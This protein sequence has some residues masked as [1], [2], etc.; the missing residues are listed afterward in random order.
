MNTTVVNI[1]AELNVPAWLSDGLDRGTVFDGCITGIIDFSAFVVVDGVSG[2]LK[3]SDFSDDF[4]H[5]SEHYKCHDHIKVRCKKACFVNG[6][7]HV[8]WEAPVKAH[9][10]QPVRC[11]LSVGMTVQAK[12]TSVRDLPAGRAA[13]ARTSEGGDPVDILCAA[14][15]AEGREVRPGEVRQILISSVN[16]NVAWNEPPRLRGRVLWER[17]SGERENPEVHQYQVWWAKI[18][19]EG[20][21]QN[22]IRPVVIV[23]NNAANVYSSV[24][25]AVPLTK[26]EKPELPTHVRTEAN[27]TP[28]IALC[29]NLISLDKSRLISC[30]DVITDAE[31]L[32]A[33][34]RALMLQLGITA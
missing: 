1:A 19:A 20:R 10:T 9:R 7:L 16:R 15:D 4:S 5:I 14:M 29:E 8:W 25:T 27:H 28:G 30:M 22:G 24:I 17:E 3:L 18:P 32:A 11:T 26:R 21:V 23:S 6:K 13:F 31:T 33:L 12:I 2:L 34:D